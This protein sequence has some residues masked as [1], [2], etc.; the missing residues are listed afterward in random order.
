MGATPIDNLLPGEDFLGIEPELLQQVDP[1]GGAVLKSFKDYAA[2][3]ANTSHVG[4]F[5]LV[6]VV[7]EVT[8]SAVNTGAAVSIEVSGE[9]GASCDRNPDE[10]AFEDLQIVDGVRLVLV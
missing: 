7:G 3:G 5:T 6:P 10:F 9:L 8:G 4:V 2:D 1:G